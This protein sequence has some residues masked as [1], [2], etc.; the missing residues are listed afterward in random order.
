MCAQNRFLACPDLHGG[1]MRAGVSFSRSCTSFDP[2]QAPVVQ[3][4]RTGRKWIETVEA[5]SRTPFDQTEFEGAASDRGAAS[6]RRR[7]QAVRLGSRGQKLSAHGGGSPAWR[8]SGSHRAPASKPQFHSPVPRAKQ[9]M[10]ASITSGS[11]REM[12]APWHAKPKDVV[13]PHMPDPMGDAPGINTSQPARK[14]LP[15]PQGLRWCR[16]RP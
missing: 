12:R 14:S 8:N 9:A 6:G 5:H 13:Q 2:Q 16:E 7:R 1:S 10:P 15:R 4:C 11:R 3:P